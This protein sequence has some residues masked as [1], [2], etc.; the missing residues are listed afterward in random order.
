MLQI[1][2]KDGTSWDALIVVNEPKLGKD[3]ANL[4]LVPLL[5]FLS[6]PNYFLEVRLKI[7]S[8]AVILG[9]SQFVIKYSNQNKGLF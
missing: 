6:F 2:N 1:G 3:V 5:T 4:L 9:R 8:L 7:T